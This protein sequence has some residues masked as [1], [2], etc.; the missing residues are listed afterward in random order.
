MNA[1]NISQI[2][3]LKKNVNPWSIDI[4]S[5]GAVLVEILTGIP[6]W[7]GY[8]CRIVFNEKNVLRNGLFA[9]KN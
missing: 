3:M 7:L 5:L 8:K 2:E 9:V 4:W 1:P 6:H